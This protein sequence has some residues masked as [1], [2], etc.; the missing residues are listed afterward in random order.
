MGP[1]DILPPNTPPPSA[2][3]FKP[4][5][6][7]AAT[8]TLLPTETRTIVPSSTQTSSPTPVRISTPTHTSAP[9]RIPSPT[10]L[11]ANTPLARASLDA[12]GLPVNARATGP[13]YSEQVNKANAHLYNYRGHNRD[14]QV[15]VEQEGVLTAE[16]E[17]ERADWCFEAWARTW[18]VFGGYAFATYECVISNRLSDPA[19]GSSGIS[20]WSRFGATNL[21]AASWKV[22]MS[23]EIFH[24]WNY[25]HLPYDELWIVE[26]QAQY[27]MNLIADPNSAVTVLNG[28]LLSYNNAVKNS[29]D[30]PLVD[31]QRSNDVLAYSK[32]ALL[33]YMLDVEVAERTRG[34]KSLDN[35]LRR[36]YLQY[37]TNGIPPGV[38]PP[39]LPRQTLYDAVIAE[40]GNPEFFSTFFRDYAE[41][42]RDLKDWH[43]GLLAGGRITFVPPHPVVN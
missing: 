20:Y 43:N 3:E 28:S 17:K 25:G 41:G 22:L 16:E 11:P 32:G 1:T 9:A 23:H 15:F 4:T 24:A 21:K 37:G 31:V 8:S 13:R 27:Y 6:L 42:T 14:L 19:R 2:V 12:P 29:I 18:N 35:V 34:A 40:A 10:P 38:R 5:P 26:G 36:L 30:L 7:G 33:F 39:A